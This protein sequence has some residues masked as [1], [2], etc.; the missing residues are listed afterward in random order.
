MEIKEARTG[1]KCWFGIHIKDDKAVQGVR[2]LDVLLG[3]TNLLH[4]GAVQDDGRPDDAVVVLIEVA[5]LGGVEA[6]EDVHR[7][8]LCVLPV[9][10]LLDAVRHYARFVDVLPGKGTSL[11][12]M[13]QQD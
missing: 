7:L 13:G 3:F 4:R 8:K 2:E 6:G 10:K 12:V 5:V 1:A 9:R 11:Q